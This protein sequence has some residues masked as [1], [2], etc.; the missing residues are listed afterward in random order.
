MLWQNLWRGRLRGQLR[1]LCQRFYVRPIRRMQAEYQVRRRL[2]RPARDQRV[3][4]NR[5][6]GQRSSVQ[7]GV[8]RQIHCFL[9][10][11]RRRLQECRRLLFGNGRQVDNVCRFDLCEL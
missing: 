6:Q 9:V 8:W 5:L 4:P 2:L 7:Y 10:L 1:H 11:L 3:V